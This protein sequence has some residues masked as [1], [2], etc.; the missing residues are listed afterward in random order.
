MGWRISWLAVKNQERTAILSSFGLHA[1]NGTHERP[2]GLI[3]GTSLP[4]GYYVLFLE[5]CFHPFVTLEVLSRVSCG[6]E[7]VGCQVD[8]RI[9]AS[10]SFCWRNGER[11]WNVTH[12]ADKGVRNLEVVGTPPEIFEHLKAEAKKL[13]DKERKIPFLPLPWEIDHF[14]SVPVD[15]SAAVVGY[16]HDRSHYPWG[17]PMYEPLAEGLV[18]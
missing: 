11:V 7:I 14:F 3:S 4:N 15:L 10:A 13:Q 2:K 1:T 6:C 8:E 5:D 18:S 9:M 17:R 12:E 16:E